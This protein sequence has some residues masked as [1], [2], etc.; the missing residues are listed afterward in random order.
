VRRV[1]I[2]G[3]GA[4]L[5]ETFTPLHWHGETFDLPAGARRL[6]ETEAVPNQAFQLG[7]RMIGLQFH[8]E[9]TPQSVQALIENA[10]HEIQD[11]QPFQQSPQAMAAQAS[12]ASAAVRP[13]LWRVLDYLTGL[14]T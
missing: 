7:P 5:P 9:A 12:H 14:R 1:T 8:V 2:E 10:A 6:A 3:A 11:G 4:L 13:V